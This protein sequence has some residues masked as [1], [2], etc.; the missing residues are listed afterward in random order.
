MQRLINPREQR[1]YDSSGMGPGETI[2]S[3]DVLNEPE[4]E[5]VHNTAASNCIPDGIDSV[6]HFTADYFQGKLVR[7]FDILFQQH[8][9]KWPERHN[10]TIRPCA[11]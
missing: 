9:I 5:T 8:K 3:D 2:E 11:I 10:S 7:H 6:N 1:F 4:L